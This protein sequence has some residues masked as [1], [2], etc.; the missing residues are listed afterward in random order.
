MREVNERKTMKRLGIGFIAFILGV[1]V[2]AVAAPT[3]LPE[4]AAATV[5]AAHAQAADAAKGLSA[6]KARGRADDKTTGLARAAEVSNSWRF[7]GGDKPGNGKALGVGR[8]DEV[9]DALAAGVSPASLESHG[10]AVSS[11]AH[12][13]VNAFERMKGKPDGRP[14]KGRDDPDEDD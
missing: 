10:E 13:M 5:A 12:E 4:H 6:D 1:P 2:A 14:G 9:H 7:T 8:S 3:D 11:A